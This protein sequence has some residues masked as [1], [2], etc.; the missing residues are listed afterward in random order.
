MEDQSELT[1]PLQNQDPTSE[2]EV[3]SE[4]AE[5]ATEVDEEVDSVVAE[6]EEVEEEEL[7]MKVNSFKT[8]KRLNFINSNS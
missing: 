1:C 3:D 6:V 8:L 4:V 7:S 2:E 5:E